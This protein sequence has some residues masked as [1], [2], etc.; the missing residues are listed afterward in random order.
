MHLQLPE[1]YVISERLKNASESDIEKILSIG[2][3]VFFEGYQSANKDLF[4]KKYEILKNNLEKEHMQ[5]L[6]IE[7]SRC[8]GLIQ[9]NENLQK[10]ISSMKEMYKTQIDQYNYQISNLQ[11]KM[12]NLSSDSQNIMLSKIESLLGYGN[13][14]DNIEKGN[15]GENYVYNH[16]IEQFPESNIDDVSG[17]T[18]S[19][20]LI[21]SMDY[22]FKCLVEVKNVAHAKNLNIEKF[23]RDVTMNSE[24]H[25]INCG[26]FVSLKTDHIPY[27]GKL[28]LEF[29]RGIPVIY[30]ANVFKNTHALTYAMYMMKEIQYYVS[31]NSENQPQN[32]NENVEKLMIHFNKLKNDFINHQSIIEE[33]EKS[34]TKT[35]IYL[36]KL[37]K[38]TETI[39]KEHSY[40]LKQCNL[41]SSV[42]H[43]KTLNKEQCISIILD[44]YKKHQK[45]PSGV[46]SGIS[47]HYR[48]VYKY[49]NLITLSKERYESAMQDDN[50][51]SS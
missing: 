10:S 23:E 51:M 34:C 17:T 36:N 3:F 25:V 18:A 35:N 11:D 21:W 37:I 42:T 50:T 29:V 14:I 30:V 33:L 46:E 26:L 15:Y 24:K 31:Q 32:E 5:K 4:E 19:G 8:D 48:R 9:S 41:N 40:M 43:T 49:S 1:N 47:P 28:K 12:A 44:Y 27:K 6:H 22:D 13:S 38:N 16:I 20:D 2:E 7:N 39:V 45:W